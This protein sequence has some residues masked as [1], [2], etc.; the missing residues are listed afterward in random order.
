MS[1]AVCT[2][3]VLVSELDVDDVVSRFGWTVGDFTRPVLNVLRLDV[4]LTGT[5]DGQSQAAITCTHTH[6]Y[7]KLRVAGQ[8]QTNR[9]ISDVFVTLI[10]ALNQVSRLQCYC[11]NIM[12]TI[13]IDNHARSSV[14]LYTGSDLS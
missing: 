10:S 8:G 14:S 11:N 6:K 9:Q 1:P 2:W 3:D 5:F 4:H 13:R 7:M 12:D